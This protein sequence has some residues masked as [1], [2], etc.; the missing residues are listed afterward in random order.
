[1]TA[2]KLRD[3]QIDIIEQVD[4]SRHPIIP[5]PTGGGKTVIGAAIIQ[6]ATDRGQHVLFGVHRRE[7]VMQASA[8]L[9]AVGVD[10]AILMGAESSA[11]IGQ[12]CIVAS[13][14]TLYARAFRSN[15]IERPPADIIFFDEAQHCRAPTYLELRKAYPDAK[16][17]GLTATP[18]RGDGRGLGGDLFSNLV[19]VPTYRWLIEQKYLV[20]PVVFAPIRPD[21]AGV[22]V[23]ATGDYSRS[24]LEIRMNTDVLVGGIIEHWFRFGENRPTLV[25]T[26][27]VQ[28]SVHL[29][30]EFQAAGVAAE[31]ID[32]RTPLED[33]RRIIAEFRSG[34]VKVLCNCMIFTEG[35]DEP[36]ASCLVL[37][38]PTKLLTMYRQ[39]VGRALRPHP[40]K[41]D[42]RI[43]DHSG[44]V[45]RH[46]YP[47]DE[48]EWVLSPDERA[49]NQS[50]VARAGSHRR[51]LTTCPKCA[52][53]RMEGEGCRVCSWKPE[54]RPRYLEV[55]DGELGQVGRDRSVNAPQIDR[56]SFH[57]QLVYIA[58]ER[59]YQPGWASH[60]YRKRFGEWPRSRYV[61]PMPPDPA[62]RSWVRSRMI[63]YA[64]SRASQ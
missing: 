49:V 50:E 32:A 20:P 10:H 27:G 6:A 42:A 59:G 35:F 12:R 52:A 58:Q 55:A 33:R 39:M 43:L 24:E 61:E 40:G 16:I 38:R 14:Q 25:F 51:E 62:T 54:T 23:L 45:Y 28:H 5:L 13:V 56:L 17:I 41:V 19:P 47:D 29:R 3:Y 63:A 22:R 1:M 44:A 9:L 18:A 15:R 4:A 46:G 37:A 60:Q 34:L 53:V 2:P 48:I 21:L 8:K 36:S 7:L 30:R 57:R 31:H 26:S 64:R 11:Y